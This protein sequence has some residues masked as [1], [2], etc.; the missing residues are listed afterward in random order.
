M[1][2]AGSALGW[3][4]QITIGNRPRAM[5]AEPRAF[6]SAAGERLAQEANAALRRAVSEA[7]GPSWPSLDAAPF[8]SAAQRHGMSS[9]IRL[10]GQPLT[11]RL[12]TSA[13]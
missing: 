2:Q 5:A 7:Y 11:R 13:K 8:S 3:K 6:T 4:N 12:S 9:S 1:A 10:F